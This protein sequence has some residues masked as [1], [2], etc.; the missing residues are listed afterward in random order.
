MSKLPQ[1][2]YNVSIK[3]GKFT[4]LKKTL[5]VKMWRYGNAKCDERELAEPNCF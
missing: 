5:A 2:S 1:E 3:T 4:I